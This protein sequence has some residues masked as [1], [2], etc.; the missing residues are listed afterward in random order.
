M[1]YLSNI[2]LNQIFSQG[3][4]NVTHDLPSV[5]IEIRLSVISFQAEDAKMSIICHHYKN[6]T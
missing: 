4:F 6:G 5:K 2:A 3:Q 1:D